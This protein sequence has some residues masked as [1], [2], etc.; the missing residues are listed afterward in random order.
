M[1]KMIKFCKDFLNYVKIKNNVDKYVKKISMK[2]PFVNSKN[3]SFHWI[4][5]QVK[6]ESITSP[7]EKQREQS[8]IYIFMIFSESLTWAG[9][10][11]DIE[12]STRLNLW[13]ITTTMINPNDPLI[14]I[15]FASNSSLYLTLK[16]KQN[17]N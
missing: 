9:I 14:L 11:A 13:R 12:S 8:S 15:H 6:I 17:Y 2:D 1:L 5:F 10:A 16:R 3:G 7:T 4:A